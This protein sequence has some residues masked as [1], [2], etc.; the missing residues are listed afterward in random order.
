M[1]TTKIELALLKHR[2]PLTM[3]VLFSIVGVIVGYIRDINYFFLF[4]GIGMMEMNTRI[5]MDLFPK[6]RQI[7]RIT[8]QIIIGGFFIIWLG[9]I[10]GVNFQF[11]QIFFDI[12]YASITG[13]VIQLVVSRLLMPFIFGNAFCSRACWTGAF[14]ELTNTKKSNKIVQ[15]KNILAYGYILLLIAISAY[16]LF[17]WN[18]VQNDNFRRTWIVVENLLIISTGF[19]LS[20]FIGSRSYC[21]LLCPFITIS[22]LISPYSFFKITPIKNENCISCHKCDNVCPMNIKVSNFVKDNKCIND[23]MC[24]VCERCVTSCNLNVLKLTNKMIK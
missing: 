13:A 9:L 22:S 7:I 18:P 12:Y 23:K 2:V 6:W 3:F 20:F 19:V 5:V 16:V 8:I 15:R 4:S 14:F 11:S 21:R 24:I 1:K 17:V 10:K